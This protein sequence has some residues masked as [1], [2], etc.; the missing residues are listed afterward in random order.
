ML[1]GD[2]EIDILGVGR[3]ADHDADDGALVVEQGGARAAGVERGLRLDRGGAAGDAVVVPPLIIR[4]ICETT[5]CVKDHSNVF[6]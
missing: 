3:G 1:D 4:P 6:G 2:G 5:P